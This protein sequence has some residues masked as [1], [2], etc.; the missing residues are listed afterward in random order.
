M[1]YID[2]DDI[3]ENIQSSAVTSSALDGLYDD[4]ADAVSAAIDN[5]TYRTFVVPTSATARKFRP[6]GDL[7]EVDDLD[8]IASTADLAIAVDSGETGSFVALS[9]SDWAAET[10]DLGMVTAIRAMGSFP[11]S[12]R[13]P[14][15][16]QVTA[17]WGWP[18]TPDP[19][20]RAAIIWA[21]RLV[22]RRSSPTGIMGFGEFGG[23]RLSTM[24]PD[25]RALLAP[26]RRVSRLLR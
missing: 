13:R 22:N 5:Y 8:D 20:T 9:S 4:I 1:A 17:R 16:I 18:A 2:A 19:V 23:V 6:S 7:I 10:N 11:Y 21:V 15:T 3:R 24:D 14:Q 12:R 25:V 26:Y